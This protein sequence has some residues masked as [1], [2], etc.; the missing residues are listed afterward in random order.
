MGEALLASPKTQ[1]ELDSENVSLAL[2]LRSAGHSETAIAA[3]I[4]CGVHRV[5]AYLHEAL[6]VPE[7]AHIEGARKLELQRLDAMLLALD[8]RVKAGDLY[9]IDRALKM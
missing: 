9:T 6:E 1:A 4:G 2:E 7:D 3:R 5:R 8:E